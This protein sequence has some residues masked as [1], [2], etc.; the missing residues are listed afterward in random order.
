MKKLLTFSA[1][2][3]FLLLSS[4]VIFA[5]PPMVAT[6]S[7]DKM[8][9]FYVGVD[10]P[11]SVDVAGVDPSLVSINVT[12]ATFKGGKG[13]YTINCI[14]PGTCTVDVFA[15]T[16]KGNEKVNS[17]TFRAKRIPDPYAGTGAYRFDG[18]ISKID[19]MSL[20]GIYTKLDGFDFNATFTVNSFRTTIINENQTAQEFQCTGPQFSQQAKTALT[21]TRAGSFVL[22]TDVTVTGPDGATRKIPGLTLKVR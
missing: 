3:A 7:A 5:P 18:T 10:N 1:L 14:T 8:N 4:F 22:I 17:F 16:D 21:L 20:Q 15:K 6:V 9:V 19:V 13:N 11:L 2:T 12:G